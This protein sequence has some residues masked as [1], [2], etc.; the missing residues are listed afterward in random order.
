[1]SRRESDFKTNTWEEK[2]ICTLVLL[3]CS[4]QAALGPRRF[5][6]FATLS[7]FVQIISVIVVSVSFFTREANPRPVSDPCEV[8][9]ES[10][11][12]GLGGSRR[13]WLSNLNS[14]WQKNSYSFVP[15]KIGGSCDES[16]LLANT[17]CCN[18]VGTFYTICDNNTQ[19]C[20]DG[21][22]CS[23]IRDQL[24]LDVSYW[25]LNFM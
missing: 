16:V 5:S 15:Q 21:Q 1:M 12:S 11:L 18:L 4:M 25:G 19:Y 22:G 24:F 3:V 23:C 20:E 14:E 9:L 10:Q 6:I 17:T 8:T 2:A 7:W 13:N